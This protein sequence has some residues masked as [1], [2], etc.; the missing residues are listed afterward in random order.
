MWVCASFPQSLLLRLDLDYIPASRGCLSVVDKL[1]VFL[2]AELAEIGTW[3]L[4]VPA[5]QSSKF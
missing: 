3:L 2:L 4:T 5:F 1:V